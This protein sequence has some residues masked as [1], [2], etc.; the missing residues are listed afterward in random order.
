MDES[1]D[2]L[3]DKLP[4]TKNISN[5]L[6]SST[7]EMSEYLNLVRAY[8]TGNWVTVSRHADIIGMDKDRIPVL[9][10]DAVVWADTL[11]AST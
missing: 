2:T 8:E 7:G 1:M 3:L 4:F 6:L 5:A 11:V 10:W 9:Y